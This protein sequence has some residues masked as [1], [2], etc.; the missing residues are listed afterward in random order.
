R[1]GNEDHEADVLLY[2]YDTFDHGEDGSFRIHLAHQID[3]ENGDWFTTHDHPLFKPLL[4]PNQYSYQSPMTI[5][6]GDGMFANIVGEQ[7]F[8]VNATIEF[9]P[10]AIPGGDTTAV[11]ELAVGGNLCDG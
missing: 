9:G 3:W 5:V 10:P 6:A 7:G 8:Y 2:L 1:I 11:E 4:K